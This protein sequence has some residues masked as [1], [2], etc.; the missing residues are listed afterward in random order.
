LSQFFSLY[1]ITAALA[2]SIT[3]VMLAS[4][5]HRTVRGV[6]IVSHRRLHV[7]RARRQ[8]R[9]IRASPCAT[10]H[11]LR[12]KDYHRATLISC[13]KVRPIGRARVH[14]DIAGEN[15]VEYRSLIERS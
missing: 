3:F 1:A 8:R 12:G 4:I 15:N 10:G 7:A 9:D 13:S 14:Q 2:V 6:R 5:W 11:D